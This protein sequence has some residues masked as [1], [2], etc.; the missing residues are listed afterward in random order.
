MGKFR[1]AQ[2]DTESRVD[3]CPHQRLGSDGGGTDGICKYSTE[4]EY[5]LRRMGAPKLFPLPR[6]SRSVCAIHSLP[7]IHT[8]TINHSTH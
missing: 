2:C 4:T 3:R 5:S 8:K 1:P 6:H 7:N